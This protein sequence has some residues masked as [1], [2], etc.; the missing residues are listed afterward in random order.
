MYKGCLQTHVWT[1][2]WLHIEKFNNLI[3]A[4]VESS[5]SSNSNSLRMLFEPRLL[6]KFKFIR[7]L[8][9]SNLNIYFL[10]RFKFE[11]DYLSLIHK[12]TS[13]KMLNLSSNWLNYNP[14]IM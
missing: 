6:N 7:I 8:N 13:I 11:L 9:K 4:L 14:W 1:S 5:L 12:R 2:F 3:R 10:I